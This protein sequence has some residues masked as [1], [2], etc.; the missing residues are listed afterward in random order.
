M[1]ASE[2]VALKRVA[3]C[4]E[5]TEMTSSELGRI[6]DV[7]PQTASRY[8]SRLE[9]GGYLERSLL[10][11]GQRLTLTEK[12]QSR[13]RRE[14]E[15]YRRIFEGKRDAKF[16]GRITKG[17]GEGR[18]YVSREGY[19]KQFEETLG[20]RAY[21]GTLNLELENGGPH[22]SSV[23]SEDDACELEGFEE[24]GRTFGEALCYEAE[25]GGLDAAIVIP[26]RSHYRSSVFEVISDR[27]LRDA[28]G[29]DDGDEVE[30]K[31]KC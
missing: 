26:D 28:L 22:P 25:V 31:V 1:D 23:L 29:L 20:Y 10:T 5:S 3:I 21:P 18:Y 19:Q 2:L 27:R 15:D 9:D 16:R 8:L 4:G 12:G 30:V 17:L 13:L 24:D 7:S 11:D 6:L 14:Y